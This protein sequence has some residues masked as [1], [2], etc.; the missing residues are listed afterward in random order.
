MLAEV[1]ALNGFSSW[2]TVVVR[3]FRLIVFHAMPEVTTFLGK[4][5]H[6]VCSVSMTPSKARLIGF[7]DKRNT[8][9]RCHRENL[10]GS[11]SLHFVGSHNG[12]GFWKCASSRRSECWVTWTF[13]GTCLRQP[14]RANLFPWSH[15]LEIF[16]NRWSILARFVLYVQRYCG[17]EKHQV[18]LTLSDGG[19]F[20]SLPQF[21]PN[22]VFQKVL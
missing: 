13:W 7:C 20:G 22:W 3:H 14:V 16:E 10:Q 8:S 12:N 9:I 11:T 4:M 15:N 2:F 17:R 18:P 5:C 6:S 21:V 19:L 1:E